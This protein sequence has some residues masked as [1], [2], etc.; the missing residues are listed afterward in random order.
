MHF[1][2][3]YSQEGIHVTI[4]D[5]II[6]TIVGNQDNKWIKAAI[7]LDVRK[8]SIIKFKGFLRRNWGNH[9]AL[10]DISLT[11]G[12]CEGLINHYETCQDLADDMSQEIYCP[13][14]Y[15]DL[16]NYRLSF[17]ADNN[18][19]SDQ[20][21]KTR[22]RLLQEWKSGVDSQT[23][24]FNMSTDI[25]SKP[26]CFQLHAFR[27]QHTCEAVESTTVSPVETSNR[28]SAA[29]KESTTVLLDITSSKIPVQINNV[30]HTC[31]N[32]GTHKEVQSPPYTVRQND[33]FADNQMS[34]GDEYAMVGPIGET[35][36]SKT[37]TSDSVLLLE[38]TVTGLNRT[39]LSKTSTGYEFAKPVLE[40]ENKIDD[41]D[42]YAL[43]EEG[44][45]DHS[46]NNRHK[47]LDDNIYNH[48]VDN[49]YDSEVTK[50]MMKGKKIHMI[51]SLDRKQKR[52]M[53]SQQPHERMHEIKLS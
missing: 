48:A 18:E 3:V 10:D 20:Y 24:L 31:S 19:C 38:P 45:Y 16:T 26:D 25:S 32:F 44:V 30:Q 28:E 13:K 49:I 33:T 46:G 12:T 36:F 11:E 14:G 17:E 9:V 47:G 40:T 23:F 43:S 34:N 15:I 35:S 29:A 6:W 21:K 39:Q 8:L 22:M 5:K 41:E 1:Y 52:I 42:Q 27:I 4:D 50:E 51:I 7:D 2:S 53:I 37:G